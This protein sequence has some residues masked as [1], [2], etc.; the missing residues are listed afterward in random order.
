MTTTKA[1]VTLDITDVRKAGGIEAAIVA[2]AE[3]SDTTS[4][5]AVG[6]AFSTSGPGSGWSKTHGAD[7]FAIRAFGGGSLHYIDEA[8]GRMATAI[9]VEPVEPAE[10]EAG[11]WD[12]EDGEEYGADE[13]TYDGGGG[14]VAL[15]VDWSDGSEVR[16]EVPG[17]ED[18]I[19]HPAAFAEMARAVAETHGA[20]SDRKAWAKLVLAVKDAASELDGIEAGG[21]E[22]E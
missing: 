20:K 11:K 5:G 4:S 22:A 15:R 2:W 17:I 3:G 19:A 10:G 7:D 16:L 1:H 21:I 9:P 14:W 12:D 18:A 6:P 13:V 8:D